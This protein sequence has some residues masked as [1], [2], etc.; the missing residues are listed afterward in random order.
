MREAEVGTGAMVRHIAFS[1]V[2]RILSTSKIASISTG[3]PERK[4]GH[5]SAAM[6]HHTRNADAKQL[7]DSI[8]DTF[9]SVDAASVR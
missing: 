5:A 4:A 1:F 9:V 3:V 6:R 2:L 8:G 7:D